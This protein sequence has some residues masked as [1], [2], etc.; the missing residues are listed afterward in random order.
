MFLVIPHPSVEPELV[1]VFV[2]LLE[3]RIKR[4]LV[5]IVRQDSFPTQTLLDVNLV[6]LMLG[7]QLDQENALLVLQD[8]N[9]LELD[10]NFVRQEHSRLMDVLAK[11]VL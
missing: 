5:W 2:V 10:V 1:N 6:H 9:L 4:M 7:L 8:Q 3:L 11:T